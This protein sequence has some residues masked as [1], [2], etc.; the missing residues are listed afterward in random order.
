NA[1][2]ERAKGYTAEEIIGSHFSIFYPPEAIA[3]GKPQREL[4][5]AIRNGSVEDEGWRLRKDG[6]RFWANVVITALR[7]ES[8]ELVGFAKVTRDLTER[9]RGEE[10]L[11]QSEERFRLLVDSVRDYAIFMLTPDGAV[12]TWNE[13][14][15]RLKGY[16]ADE[17]IGRHFSTFYPADVAASGFPQYELEFAERDGRFDDEGWRVRKDDS[18]FWANVIITARI[19]STGSLIGYAKVKRE[20]TE[21]RQAEERAIAYARQMAE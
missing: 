3:E 18:L 2:A 15:Q 4:Q 9:R 7:D 13:G 16:T 21:R 6:S 5:D 1:G 17:I 20:L 19:D 14:A 11:Q 10:E 12:A 8:G